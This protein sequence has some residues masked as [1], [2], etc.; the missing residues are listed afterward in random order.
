MPE[1]VYWTDRFIPLLTPF[2][3]QA[4]RDLG[5]PIHDYEILHLIDGRTTLWAMGQ[6]LE[7]P[8]AQVF[9]AILDCYRQ[10]WIDVTVDLS[11]DPPPFR[12]GALLVEAGWITTQQLEAGLQDQLLDHHRLGETLMAKGW[13]TEEQMAFALHLH[14][15]YQ[16][17]IQ[18]H[19][20]F[21]H[22]VRYEGRGRE[23]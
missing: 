8:L 19:H 16:E 11:G 21:R 22:G 14:R 12:L 2:G 18:H 23:N 3:E 20:G 1:T 10:N 17:A 5:T 13:L 7:Y 6:R 9:A 15:R 4:L